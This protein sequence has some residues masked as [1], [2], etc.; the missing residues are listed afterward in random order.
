MS[1]QM[2][3]IIFLPF[4]IHNLGSRDPCSHAGN[5]SL[6]P[7]WMLHTW[8]RSDNHLALTSSWLPWLLAAHQYTWF[9]TDCAQSRSILHPDFFPAAMIFFFMPKTCHII[10][11]LMLILHIYHF[12]TF[13]HILNI[14][15]M[16]DVR[17]LFPNVL[18]HLAV[19]VCNQFTN[20]NTSGLDMAK[21]SLEPLELA[22]S[23]D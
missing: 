18:F 6:C 11:A 2:S 23:F 16:Y 13:C 3:I 8:F 19:L 10:S 17:I 4:L 5:K 20:Y 22:T 7:S 9:D 12:L 1:I 21:S 15:G 14:E